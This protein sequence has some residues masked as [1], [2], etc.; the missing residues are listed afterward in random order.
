MPESVELFFNVL[1]MFLNSLEFIALIVSVVTF[2][3]LMFNQYSLALRRILAPM[4]LGFFQ[5]IMVLFICRKSAVKKRA[6]IEFAMLKTEG[7]S[8]IKSKWS[9]IINEFKTFYTDSQGS[10]VYTLPN[11]TLLIGTDFSKA[12]ARYFEYFAKEKVKKTYGIKDDRIE[13]VVKLHIEEAY[14]TPT[15]LLTG[16]LS[17]YEEN[18]ADFIKRYVSTAYMTELQ[19]N[20]ATAILSDELYMTFAWLLW[21]PSY[22]LD[23]ENYWSGLCQMSFGDESNSI[24]AVAAPNGSIAKLIAE[25][26]KSN[27][28]KRYG[29]LLSVDLSVYENKSYIKEYRQNVSPEYMYFYDKI[30]NG[31]TSFALQINA[32]LPYEGYKAQKYYCTAYVWLLFELEDEENYGFRPE[33]SVA[34]FEHSNLTDMH[35]YQYLVEMLIG[36]SMSHFEQIFREPSLKGRKYR[37]VCAMNKGIE[38]ACK[39]KYRKRAEAGDPLAQEFASRIILDKKRNP[40]EAFLAFDE[41]F[42]PGVNMT[43]SEVRLNEKESIV[44]LGAFYTEIYM[45]C[46]PD[47][48]ERE[49]FDNLLKYLKN[50]A[51]PKNRTKYTYHIVLVKDENDR[52]V[53]GAIFDY[54][55]RS[56]SGVIEFIAVKKNAQSS[57]I[58]TLL[59]NHILLKMEQDAYL[60][61]RQK[62]A[63]VFCEI[64][65]PDHSRADVKKYLYFWNKHRYKRI[66]M[67]YIQPSLSA[68]QEPVRGLWLT[69]TSPYE[70]MSKISSKLVIDVIHD[71]MQYAMQIDPPADDEIYQ[72]MEREL[73]RSETVTL[74]E[75]L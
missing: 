67:E 56:N 38:E 20:R 55:I 73:G 1:E 54:F 41:F 15:C 57:G 46:F 28:G 2:F 37:L 5:R 42:T 72:K 33:T 4:G 68:Q 18:W 3:Y 12:V 75:I 19:E 8:A 51:D 48:D 39:E 22:E 6:F 43:Y 40:A 44:E 36:K 61:S 7:H 53:A 35:T 25:R 27:E 45:D 30:E 9:R 21:G 50:A 64:D 52:I 29:A 17:R 70:Q 71:Y 58:G 32:F 47:E 23:Y 26:F 62:L 59:Y 13:W 49:T 10:L 31:D 60:Y 69:V 14:A 63:Y 66:D 74:S 34:F 16:L 65:A 11:C 24:P